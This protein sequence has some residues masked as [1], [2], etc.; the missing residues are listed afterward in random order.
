MM[1]YMIECQMV[2]CSTLVPATA[3][4]RSPMVDNESN[5]HLVNK[6]VSLIA[7]VVSEIMIIY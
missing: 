5:L 1:V 6:C 4:A 7:S 2:G 3:N